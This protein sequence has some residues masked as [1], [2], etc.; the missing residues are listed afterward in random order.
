METHITVYVERKGTHAS[1]LRFHSAW[2][3]TRAESGNTRML[4]SLK[5]GWWGFRARLL[6][7]CCQW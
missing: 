6:A 4:G 2:T 3:R 5:E 7:Q 1:S